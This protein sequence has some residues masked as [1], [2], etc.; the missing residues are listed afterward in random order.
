MTMCVPWSLWETTTI[1]QPLS[2]IFVLCAI[3]APLWAMIVVGTSR[4]LPDR[5]PLAVR[6]EL[7]PIGRL[8]LTLETGT[9]GRLSNVEVVMPARECGCGRPTR[10]RPHRHAGPGRD[11]E[12][13]RGV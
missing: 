7:V 10:P 1:A 3:R 8:T 9:S 12:T 5:R 6:A 11:R 4:F 2:V 13:R